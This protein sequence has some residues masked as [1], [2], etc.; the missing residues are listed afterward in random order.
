MQVL[1]MRSRRIL[2]GILAVALGV[3][4]VMTLAKDPHVVD[5]TVGIVGII[6]AVLLAVV[7]VLPGTRLRLDIS[8]FLSA[9]ICLGACQGTL[10]RKLS[11]A[12]AMVIPAGVIAVCCA[13]VAVMVQADIDSQ[14]TRDRL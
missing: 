14:R 7:A 4:A 10:G 12:G 6:V 11:A 5:V 8:A 1:Y 13:T 3:C 9:A 2:A